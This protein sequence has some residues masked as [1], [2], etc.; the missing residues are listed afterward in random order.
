MQ[1]CPQDFKALIIIGCLCGILISIVVTWI[2]FLIGISAGAPTRCSF[3]LL[4]TMFKN[5]NQ[6]K[7]T[8]EIQLHP[9][10]IKEAKSLTSWSPQEK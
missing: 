3:A 2:Y 7:L 10:Q 6:Q 1:C 4:Y 9:E 5:K 8:Q